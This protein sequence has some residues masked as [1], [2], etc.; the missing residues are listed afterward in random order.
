MLTS[1]RRRLAFT[2]IELLVVIAII[3]V[4]IALLLPAVQQ[5]REAARRTQCKN[6][7]KQLGLAL[8]NYHDTFNRLPVTHF[9]VNQP[10]ATWDQQEKGTYFCR[11]LPFIEQAP[12]F[13]LIDFKKLQVDPQKDA[14]GV[15]LIR[16]YTIPVFM[17]PS[18]GSP[19]QWGGD[20]AKT[21]YAMSI[22]SQALPANPASP[23]TGYPGNVFGTGPTGHAN[24][25]QG[26]DVSGIISRFNWSAKFG[27]I[28]D[29][30][31]NTI[32]MARSGRTAATTRS[33]AGNTS[34]ASSSP[35]RRRSIIR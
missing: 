1:R 35:R 21:N 25:E 33:T 12:L 8:H 29:G 19:D 24:S 30:L 27:D 3:A 6:N 5:A 14:G 4:L 28:S 31:S 22:G 11:L 23:C 17:C 10:G 26:T 20:R 16:N 18:D 7:L 34:T 2:L 13:Q 15:R 32:A 9:N